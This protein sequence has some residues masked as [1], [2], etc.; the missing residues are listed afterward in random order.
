MQLK[1]LNRG[2]RA[3][4]ECLWGAG[5]PRVV[6]PSKEGAGSLHPPL[7]LY[8]FKDSKPG[9]ICAGLLSWGA[10]FVTFG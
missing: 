5:F 9:P 10:G 6:P 1:T 8:A 2:L 7:F 3:S 4:V